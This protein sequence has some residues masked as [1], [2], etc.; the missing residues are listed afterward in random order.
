MATELTLPEET[1]EEETTEEEGWQDAEGLGVISDE[2][3]EPAE[4][5]TRGDYDPNLNP[6]GRT[7][8][9]ANLRKSGGFGGPGSGDSEGR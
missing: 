4:E 7:Y 1:T 2:G 9:G 8:E 3:T 6:G 5:G